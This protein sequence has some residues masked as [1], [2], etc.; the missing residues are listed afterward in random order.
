MF[1]KKSVER[2]NNAEIISISSASIDI[3]AGSNTKMFESDLTI[4]HINNRVRFNV[5]TLNEHIDCLWQMSTN[6]GEIFLA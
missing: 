2:K 3:R 1:Y 6:I 5:N 4:V